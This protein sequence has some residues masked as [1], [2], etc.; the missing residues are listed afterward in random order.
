MGIQAL[1]GRQA[2]LVDPREIKVDD[3]MRDAGRLRQVESVEDDDFRLSTG[4]LVRFS[5]SENGPYATLSIPDGVTVT[6]WR[7]PDETPGVCRA[8][9]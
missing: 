4:V 6:V 9:A 8:A 2:V 7:A 5:D 3:W 1:D